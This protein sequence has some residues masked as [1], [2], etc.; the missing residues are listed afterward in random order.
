VEK[1]PILFFSTFGSKINEFEQKKLEKTKK[2]P[3]TLASNSHKFFKYFT[4]K[5]K[6]INIYGSNFCK[7]LETVSGWK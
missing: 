3:G 1:T 4:W 5:I 7:L 2:F 6:M